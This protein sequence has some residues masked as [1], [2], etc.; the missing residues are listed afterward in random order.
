MLKLRSRP[1]GF[2][3]VRRSASGGHLLPVLT[4]LTDLTDLK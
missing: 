1:H 2:G 3:Q 4:D